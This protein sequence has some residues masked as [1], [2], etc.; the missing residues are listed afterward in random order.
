[1]EKKRIF[2]AIDISDEARHAVAT[3]IDALRHDFRDV[4][5]RWEKPEKLH[6]TLKFAGSI[7]EAALNSLTSDVE[8]AAAE[9]NPF[10]ITLAETGAFVRRSSR[11][12]VLWIGLQQR[13]VMDELAAKIDPKTVQRRFKAHITIARLKDAKK[14]QLLIERH[15][16]SAF[17]AVTFSVEGV[18]IYESTLLPTGS[19]YN[20][21]SRHRCGKPG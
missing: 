21:I 1:M 7:D 20:V 17:E 19:V 10:A 5:V 6:I 8:A 13:Y 2:A 12:N 16:S 18:T 11:A 4:P 9:T 14:A 15:L 3:Y